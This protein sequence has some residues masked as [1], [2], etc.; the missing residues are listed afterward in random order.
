MNRRIFLKF[1]G[2]TVASL[3]LSGCRKHLLKPSAKKPNVLFIAIDDMNDW[4]GFLGGHPQAKTPNMDRLAEKA[5]N[6]RNAHIP[7]PACSPCRNALL[8]G[9]QPFHSG[10]YP[11]YQRAKIK[12]EILAGYTTLPRLFKENG[13][14]T[15]TSGK[16]HH[17]TPWTYEKDTATYEW[18]EHNHE[19]LSSLPEL[20]YDT[21]LGYVAPGRRDT[22]TFCP[23]TSPLEHHLDYVT[24][25]YGIEV[26]G[27]LHDKPFFLALGFIKPHLPFVA[28]KK[29][30]DLYSDPIK[31]PAIK[32]DDLADVPWP[33]RSNAMLRDDLQFRKDKAWEKVRRAY[34]ACISWTDANV[35]RVLDAL[36]KSPW[37]DNT[38]VVLWSDHG[39]HL[40]EKRSF[41][42][43]SLWEEVTRVP[44]LIL[45]T[46]HKVMKGR[47]CDEPVS[48]IDIYP[49]LTDLVGLKQPDYVDGVSLVPWLKN[50]SQVREE[51]AITTWGRGNYTVRTRNWRYIRYFDGSEEL[52]YHK[53][54]PDEWK[55]LA[56]LSEFAAK[57]EELKKWLPKKESPLVLSGK[58]VHFGGDADKPDLNNIKTIWKWINARIKPPLE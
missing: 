39:F 30:F 56:G 47:R 25:Q 18:T 49:T 26:L 6:F 11:Y 8:F 43:F 35:G 14:N 33:G 20:V 38:I 10:L 37:R 7:A 3:A 36:E 16:V 9:I 12:P 31:P 28:P 29:Y 27:R 42:K 32:A 24:S 50:P 53:Q 40:G 15:F 21:K 54:D 1:T 17:G 22:W 34:L 2:F 51:P 52:Y 5:V 13:Y 46:R 45:D 44:F 23:T 58:A 41:R 55:N 4:V 48:L 57:K 19:T